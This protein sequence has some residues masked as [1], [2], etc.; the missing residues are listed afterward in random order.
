MNK[1]DEKQECSHSSELILRHEREFGELAQVTKALVEQSGHIAKSIELFN[2]TVTD[3]KIIMSKQEEHINSILDV[4]E[5]QESIKDLAHEIKRKQDLH[6]QLEAA[7]REEIK[8]T[9]DQL[10]QDTSHIKLFNKPLKVIQEKSL[11]YGLLVA[12]FAVVF[13]CIKNY[14]IVAALFGINL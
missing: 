10:N 2:E 12:I 13:F 3:I 5:Q 4:K 11:F 14:K 7:E 6:E 1:K 9:L 8:K